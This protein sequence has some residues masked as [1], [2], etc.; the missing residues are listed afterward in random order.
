MNLPLQSGSYSNALA[1][2]AAV[3]KTETIKFLVEKRADMN[4]Q[5]QNENYGSALATT[6]Y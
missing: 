3:E 1:T 2:T 4:V 5:L 6:A